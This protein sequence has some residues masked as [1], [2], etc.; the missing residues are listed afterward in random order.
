MKV[1]VNKRNEEF[2]CMFRNISR[3]LHPMVNSLREKIFCVFFKFTFLKCVVKLPITKFFIHQTDFSIIQ[4][5]Q[6]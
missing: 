5:I 6:K 3:N 4:G 2:V 1:K